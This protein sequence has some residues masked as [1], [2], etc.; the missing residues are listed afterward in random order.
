[1]PRIDSPELGFWM[2]SAV[3]ICEEEFG[4]RKGGCFF[5][6]LVVLAHLV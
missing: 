6:G 5:D 4:M 3:M 2:R 1:M